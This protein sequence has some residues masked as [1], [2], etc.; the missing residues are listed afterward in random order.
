[1]ERRTEVGAVVGEDAGLVRH[2]LDDLCLTRIDHHVHVVFE[3]TETVQLVGRLLDVGNV[4]RHLIA[5]VYLDLVRFEA[6]AHRDQFDGYICAAARER[7]ILHVPDGVRVLVLLFRIDLN[8]LQLVS[9]D[10]LRIVRLRLGESVIEQLHLLAADVYELRAFRLRRA[11]VHVPPV[12]KLVEGDE[13]LAV[14][15]DG[16]AF[17]RGEVADVVADRY[18]VCYFP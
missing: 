6:T 5:L 18:F 4:N 2:K 17:G 7:C 1:M 15:V 12:R 8:R 13:V 14:G 16:V 11:D 10:Q 9:L 3:Q